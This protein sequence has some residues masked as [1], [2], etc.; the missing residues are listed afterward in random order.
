MKI[1]KRA[2]KQSLQLA[3]W[4]IAAFLAMLTLATVLASVWYVHVM[5]EKYADETLYRTD[6]YVRS[7][8]FFAFQFQDR[9]NRLGEALEVTSSVYA[10]KQT[11]YVE[12][13]DIP[14][15]LIDAF[16]AIE[17]KRFWE[18]EGVDWYRTLAA[19]ANYL[20]G[21]SD[22]FGASTITQQLVKNMTGNDQLTPKRKLQEIFYAIDLERNLDKSEIMELYLNVIH[23]SDQCNGIAA[24]SEHY[25]SKMPSELTVSECATIAA[26]TNNPAY[27]NPI[28]HPEHN[29]ARR[30]L[31]LSEMHA[32]GYLSDQEYLEAKEA[33]IALCVDESN[34]TEGINSWYTDMVIEDVINDLCMQYGMSR[35]A[36]SH[37]FYT[38]GL[39]IDMAMDEEIQKTVERYY[40]DRISVPKTEDGTQAQ[41]ALIVIDSRTGDILGV[42]GAV[43]E[44]RGNHLQNFATQTKRSPGSTIK[45]L[46]VYAPA[47]EKELINFASVYD[48]VPVE[49]GSNGSRMWPKNATGIYRGLTNIAYAVAHS[50]NTVSVRVLQELGL[51]NS[52]QFAKDKFHLDSLIDC[53]GESDCDLAALALG[54]LHYGVTLRELTCA[55]TAFADGGVYHPY[56]S[57]YRVLDSDGKILLSCPD[58]GEVVLKHQNADLMTKLLQGVVAN[59]TSGM[60]DLDRICECAG[61]TG[62]TNRDCDRWFVGYTPDLVCGVWSGYEYPQPMEGKNISTRIWNDVMKQILQNASYRTAFSM[63]TELV[64]A[65]YCKDSGKLMSEACVKD[66]RGERSEVGWFIRGTEPKEFCDCHVLCAY[67]SLNG[68]VSHGF[69]PEETLTEIGLIRVERRFPKNVSVLD[70]QYVYGG[71][72]EAMPPNLSESEPYFGGDGGG[73][74]RGKSAVASPYHRSCPVHRRR[75]EEQEDSLRDPEVL[76]IPWRMYDPFE[77]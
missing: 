5:Y 22:T 45:P 58:S 17:D 42:A 65:T 40:R 38:G 8:Q 75:E 57:Y 71:E 43:G 70:A 23:F 56:R 63:S 20:L 39:R 77:E 59:G 55:Y 72:A 30:N 52:F 24:A 7:P 26:I 48:D 6:A 74:Y 53:T 28:R 33:P 35:A 34:E 50:T 27:Y 12:Y 44:K 19:G 68:G 54:Q 46:S 64:R 25:Y 31:I 36:A 32:Q 10:Q 69:C 61:K 37:L 1:K 66:P 15:D 47:L 11:A 73:I 41:S 62:T 60:I 2:K 4:I 76:P 13:R 51:R 67:D 3:L 9:T 49:F 18:H 16:V 21:F 14:K 29:L